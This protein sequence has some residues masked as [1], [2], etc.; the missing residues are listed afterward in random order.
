M[1]PIVIINC[2]FYMNLGYEAL[3]YLAVDASTD[4]CN[5]VILYFGRITLRYVPLD[6]IMK[7][8]NKMPVYHRWEWNFV[9]HT[10]MER[11]LEIQS[12][13]HDLMYVK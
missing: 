4:L 8:K 6:Y 13:K 2:M 1:H 3:H 11:F 9:Y 7:Q 10:A 12:N 5:C